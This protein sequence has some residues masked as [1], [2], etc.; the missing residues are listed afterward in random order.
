MRLFILLLWWLFCFGWFC[1][2]WAIVFH[3]VFKFW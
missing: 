1:A 2:F 3:F